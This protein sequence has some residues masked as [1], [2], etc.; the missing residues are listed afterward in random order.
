MWLLIEA[1]L[2]VLSSGLLFN[3][4]FRANGLL[5]G[6]AAVIAI[7]SSYLLFEEVAR[8]VAREVVAEQRSPPTASKSQVTTTPAVAAAP[9]LT[10]PP[11]PQLPELCSTPYT[12][13]AHCP[14]GQKCLVVRCVRG[15]RQISNI[16]ILGKDAYGSYVYPPMCMDPR[17]RSV[18]RVT[19]PEGWR[20]LMAQIRVVPGLR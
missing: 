16:A 9:V 12:D 1:S 20:A 11:T 4:R 10:P 8:R 3:E 15:C 6:I 17:E 18:N 14:P 7:V 5:V 13:P 2:F 19:D